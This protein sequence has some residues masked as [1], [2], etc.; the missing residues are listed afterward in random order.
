M[1]TITCLIT[2]WMPR[3]LKTLIQM[4]MANF[5]QLRFLVP[6]MPCSIQRAVATPWNFSQTMVKFSAYIHDFKLIRIA[7]SR[8]WLVFIF[9]LFVFNRI[10]WGWSSSVGLCL[11]QWWKHELVLGRSLNWRMCFC[12]K[13]GGSFC[14]SDPT[15]N[16]SVFL[17]FSWISKVI[18][19]FLMQKK[20][21]SK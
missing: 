2:K 18:R 4:M 11:W 13:L 5:P 15:T 21:N 3:I 12:S 17:N 16:S 6:L 1:L 8:S 19:L 9:L 14:S 7:V 10:H 20:S